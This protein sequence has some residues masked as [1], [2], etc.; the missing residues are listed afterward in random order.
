MSHIKYLP[1]TQASSYFIWYHNSSLSEALK[2]KLYKKRGFFY[3]S[4]L[5][6][7][8][9]PVKNKGHLYEKHLLPKHLV[10]YMDLQCGIITLDCMNFSA[11]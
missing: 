5:Y 7:S 2:G 6:V 4:F 11:M 9:I 8:V 10:F 3:Q 1:Q